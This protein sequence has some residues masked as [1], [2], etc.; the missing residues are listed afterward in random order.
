MVGGSLQPRPKVEAVT[1]AALAREEASR[2][3]MTR[4]RG[5]CE[6][7]TQQ[8]Q[9]HLHVADPIIPQPQR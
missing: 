7:L 3:R 2:E 4:H 1:L 6:T 8:W 5:R 9:L